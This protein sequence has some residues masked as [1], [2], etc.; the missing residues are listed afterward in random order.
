MIR[1]SEFHAAKHPSKIG[2][3]RAERSTTSP[4]VGPLEPSHSA[5][6]GA[7]VGPSRATRRC[8]HRSLR[9]LPADR[10]G[11][12]LG[13]VI[14]AVD[15]LPIDAPEALRYR[16]ATRVIGSTAQF[17][18]VRGG[19]LRHPISLESP[20]DRPP[21]DEQWMPNLSP[22]HGA[23]VA[24]LSPAVAEEIGVD[25]GIS[26]VAVTEVRSGAV[27][28]HL[29]LRADDIIR[30]IDGKPISTVEG[31]LAFHVTPFKSSRVA[32]RTLT[33]S[34]SISRIDPP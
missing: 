18:V 28:Y 30:G 9:G 27:D 12:K 26:G 19:K 20:P 29:G 6:I 34:I 11:L 2:Q 10:A 5:A 1:C 31:L 32:S 4:A 21:N 3:S 17:A 13:D 25:S 33:I 23:R 14:V 16:I 7:I 8:R 24:S 15:E 22:I